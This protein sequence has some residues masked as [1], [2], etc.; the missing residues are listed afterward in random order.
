[1]GVGSGYQ[2]GSRGGFDSGI[3][4]VRPLCRSGDDCKA[5]SRYK[6]DRFAMGLCPG[7]ASGC[8]RTRLPRKM[9]HNARTRNH[10]ARR[11][12]RQAVDRMK[13]TY[14]LTPRS[15]PLIGDG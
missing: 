2:D 10:D 9:R 4:D 7:V 3:A 12:V 5:W 13:I 8:I 6:V 14:M 15:L 1:M 11:S